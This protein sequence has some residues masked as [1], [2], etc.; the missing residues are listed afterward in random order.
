MLDEVVFQLIT[1]PHLENN[2][3]SLAGGLINEYA[4]RLPGF[5]DRPLRR[6]GSRVRLSPAYNA[7]KG[8]RPGPGGGL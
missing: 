7:V 3:G 8:S 1:I 4:R 6:P 2:V 5:C